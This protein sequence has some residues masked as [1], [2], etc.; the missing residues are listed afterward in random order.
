VHRV[1]WRQESE[2]METDRHYFLEGLFI[3]VLAIGAA[4]AFVWLSATGHRDDLVY[5][6]RFADSVSGLTVGDPVKFRGVDVGTVKAIALDSADPR[7][8]QVDV[9]LRKETPVKTDT[10][11]VLRLK[12]ITGVVFVEL[13]GGAPNAK[14]LVAV[15]PEGQVPEI[16]SDKSPLTAVLDQLPRILEKF[17]GIE[18]QVKK[19]AT[20]VGGLTGTLK[21]DPSQLIFGKKDKTKE[22]KQAPAVDPK[23]RDHGN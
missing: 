18:D 16:P 23:T 20:D 10:R 21:E 7:L 9:R 8:V 4:L 17:S 5:Q 1:R 12:G 14:T 11:A 15:T 19:V 3:I 2:A 22:A 6:I 13:N